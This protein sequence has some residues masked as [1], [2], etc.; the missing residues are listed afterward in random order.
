VFGLL[1]VPD[2]MKMHLAVGTSLAIIIPTSISSFRTHLSKGKVLMDVLRVWSI[3]VI[4]G[5]VLGS[6]VAAF[7]SD[8]VL[9]A[10][11]VVVALL[12][13]SKLLFGRDHWRLG[14]V[15][16]GRAGL[17]AFGFVLGTASALM[18]IGGSS[19]RLRRCWL[20]MARGWPTIRPSGNSK[21]PSGFSCC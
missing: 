7:A 16:P 4:A 15:L 20:P 19:R 1:D 5:V 21:S 17:S 18:G 11:F 12:N 10:V 2:A 14:A 8:A 13:A 9:K 3:P 6:A